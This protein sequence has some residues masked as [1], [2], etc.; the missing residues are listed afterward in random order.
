MNFPLQKYKRGEEYCTFFDIQNVF[1]NSYISER[2]G[3]FATRLVGDLSYA[4]AE[5]WLN[6]QISDKLITGASIRNIVVEKANEISTKQYNEVT[7]N[8]AIPIPKLAKTVNIY[9]KRKGEILLFEDGIL[10][11]GQK[12]FRDSK[13]RPAESKEGHKKRPTT[14]VALCPNLD[15]SHTYV[16]GGI[17]E[18]SIPLSQAIRHHM[19]IEFQNSKS[20]LKLVTITDGASQ[21]TTHYKEAFG[22]NPIRILDWY[23]LKKKV[24]ELCIQICYSKKL[25]QIAVK[26]ILG[27]LWLGNQKEAIE[28]LNTEVEVRNEFKF[29]ELVNYLTKHKEALIDYKT[30]KELGK[31]IGSGCIETGVKQIVA[32]RQKARGMAWTPKGSSALAILKTHELNGDWDKL[33]SF[34]LN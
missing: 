19:A 7:E 20:A 8:Q 9:S 1:Q 16:I 23:H 2:L 6:N 4:K 24:N 15:G 28:Y 14:D 3:E 33:W 12:Y 17:G 13:N 10:T 27:H 29:N 5:K 21:I 25:R 32:V 31:T 26:A 18:H 11:K 30:R 22:V 34:N